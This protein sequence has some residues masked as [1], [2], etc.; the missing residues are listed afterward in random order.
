MELLQ[1]IL[2]QSK[3]EKKIVCIYLN[4][5]DIDFWCGYVKD[6]TDEHVIMVH[7]TKFGHFDGIIIEQLAAIEQ[8]CFDNDYC[9]AMEFLVKNNSLLYQYNESGTSIEIGANWQYDILEQQL[10]NTNSI[11]KIEMDKDTIHCG[12]VKWLDE[13]N[14]ILNMLDADGKNEGTSVFKTNDITMIKVN[15]LESRRRLLLSKWR[16][17]GPQ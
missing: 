15:D 14:V 16:N 6:F 9:E 5:E 11:V 13:D 17:N 8:I 3:E 7:Y 4:G 10:N 1:N 2:R 12:L